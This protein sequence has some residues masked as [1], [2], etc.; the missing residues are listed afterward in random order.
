VLID[1]PAIHVWVLTDIDDAEAEARIVGAE[2]EYLASTPDHQFELDVLPLDS[3]SEE[4][5]PEFET[6][7]ER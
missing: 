3:I 5:L 1:S 6:V 7:L 2:R 4:M